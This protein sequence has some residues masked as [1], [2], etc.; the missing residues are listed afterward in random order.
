PSDTIVTFAS[1]NPAVATVPPSVTIPAGALS[2][3]FSVTSIAPGVTTIS[4]T[5]PASVGGT[6][7]SCTTTVINPTISLTRTYST[8]IAGNSNSGTVTLNQPLLT[9]P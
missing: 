3:N 9:D 1:T 7:Q 4:A 2:A 6:P 8:F 5:P